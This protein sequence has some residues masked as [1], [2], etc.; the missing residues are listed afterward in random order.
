MRRS[1][2]NPSRVAPTA[3]VLVA[4]ALVI[5][6]GEAGAGRASAALPAASALDQTSLV[7]VPKP[8]VFPAPCHVPNVIGLTLRRARLR[9]SRAHCWVGSIRRVR[10][11]RIGQVVRQRPLPGAMRTW[12]FQVRLT[13]GRRRGR[14]AQAAFPGEP[15]RISFMSN[16]SG[17][18]DIYAVKPNGKDVVQLTT[19]PAVDQ[20]PS[21]SSDGSKIVFTSTRDGNAE[22][23][24][25]NAD[26]SGQTRLTTNP[27]FDE[28]PVFSPDG[29]KIAF[30][31]TRDAP[32]ACPADRLP[33]VCVPYSEVYVMDADGS[34]VVRL[35]ANSTLDRFPMF[36]PHG[37]TIAFTANRDGNTEIYVMNADG[38][39]QTRITNGLGG[40]S[41]PSWS[42]DGTR[43]A[44]RSSPVEHP[45]IG[46][47]WVMNADGTDPT[48]LT[49]D[50][51]DDLRPTWSPS[52]A[53][54]AFRSLRTNQGDIYLMKADGSHEEQLTDDPLLDAYPDWQPLAEEGD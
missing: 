43:I 21:Y 46:D 35:T 50:P 45:E 24:E 17:N 26:G 38:S 13:L 25:M 7:P 14:V 54:I 44:W 18:F 28:N 19:D 53:K 29:S 6:C 30:A 41:Q 40:D 48:Q 23:Y 10:A 42:P 47:I 33:A 16:R 51:T 32:I 36:S 12:R 34:N 15:G 52:G 8:G 5:A 11:R 31:S 37:S 9:V 4:T 49:D 27:G 1:L 22:V 39:D 3:V 20:F 2:S